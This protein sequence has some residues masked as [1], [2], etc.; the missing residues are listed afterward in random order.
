MG[1]RRRPTYKNT[2]SAQR[3]FKLDTVTS[4][5]KMLLVREKSGNFDFSSLW[6]PCLSKSNWLDTIDHVLLLMIMI[7]SYSIVHLKPD[8]KS[9]KSVHMLHLKYLAMYIVIYKDNKRPSTD[10]GYLSNFVWR[11]S[12]RGSSPQIYVKAYF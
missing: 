12:S 4:Q 8:N 2:S 9:N 10:T 11:R 5:G 7:E 3:S 6:E 1:K